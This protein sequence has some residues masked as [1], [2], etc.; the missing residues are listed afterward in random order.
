[1]FPVLV[2]P[3][4]P[5]GDSHI[6]PTAAPQFEC[7]VCARCG[8]DLHSLREGAGEGGR[9]RVPVPEAMAPAYGDEPFG[10]VDWFS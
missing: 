7:G 8:S 2:C 6:S 9:A 5:G 10:T 1:M 4:A 3:G